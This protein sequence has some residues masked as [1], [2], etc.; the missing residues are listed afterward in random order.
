MLR[1]APDLS[2]L[3]GGGAAFW[4]VEEG[5]AATFAKRVSGQVGWDCAWMAWFVWCGGSSVMPVRAGDCRFRLAWQ[6]SGETTL[7]YDRRPEHP[8][9]EGRGAWLEASVHFLHR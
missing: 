2:A 8:H 4:Q 9:H 7:S 5:D 6:R 3:P 1:R